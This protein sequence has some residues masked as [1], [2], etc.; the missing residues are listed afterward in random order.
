MK[1]FPSKSHSDLVDGWCVIVLFETMRLR[2][3]ASFPIRMNGQFGFIVVISLQIDA[4][5]PLHIFEGNVSSD[6]MRG[7][8]SE[9]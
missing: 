5:I 1:H 9:F 2:Y 3:S 6:R 4:V 8:V 7:D